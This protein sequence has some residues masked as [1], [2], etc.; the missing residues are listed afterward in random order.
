MEDDK[1]GGLGIDVHGAQ[2]LAYSP[3]FCFQ[4]LDM[5]P[6]HAGEGARLS[7]SASSRTHAYG[8]DHVTHALTETCLDT[9]RDELRHQRRVRA[10]G[11]APERGVARGLGRGRGDRVPERREQR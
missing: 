8:L 7:A 1:T 6:S 2:A 9:Q 4:A 5:A 3:E 11:H 10:G